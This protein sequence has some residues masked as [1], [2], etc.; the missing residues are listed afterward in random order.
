[1]ALLTDS[2]INEA[3]RRL[4][5]WSR[6]S[7][8]IR[9]QFTF[10]SFPEAVEFV[11][12]LVPEAEAADHHPDLTIN[13]RHCPVTKDAASEHSHITLSAISSGCPNLPMGSACH[14]KKGA[15]RSATG[16]HAIG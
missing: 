6:E 1:M 4:Q 15:T 2:E 14:V 10:G 9:K 11:N 12:R 7:N 5:G 16:A 8:A 3:L 13:Y